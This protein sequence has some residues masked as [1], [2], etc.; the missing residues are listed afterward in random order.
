MPKIHKPP[1]S[2][3]I[4]EMIAID[5]WLLKHGGEAVPSMAAMRAA[6]EKFLRPE[7]RQLP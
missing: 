3:T 4:D 6:Y 7:G 1:I 5:T 2:L